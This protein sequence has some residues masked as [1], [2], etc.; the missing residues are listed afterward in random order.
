MPTLLTSPEAGSTVVACHA[1]EERRLAPAMLR[2][3]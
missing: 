3:G 1:V 2:A